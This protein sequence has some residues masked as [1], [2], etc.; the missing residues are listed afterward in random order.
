LL[1]LAIAALL[2]GGLALAVLWLTPGEAEQKAAM[3][4]SGMTEKHVC[5]LLRSPVAE[6]PTL[7][8]G[9]F[10]DLYEVSFLQSDSSTVFVVFNWREGNSERRVASFRTMP[11]PH[12]LT[13]LRRTL[14][15]LPP[16]LAE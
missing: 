11:P 15:C 12:P 5:E 8:S 2:V 13:R 16:F 9:V 6:H 1:G 10:P 4:Q 14:A 3:I 7:V